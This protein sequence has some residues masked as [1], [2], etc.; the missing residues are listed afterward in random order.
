[1]DIK[2]LKECGIEAIKDS[3]L[4]VLDR[5]CLLLFAFAMGMLAYTLMY[6]TGAFYIMVLCAMVCVGI[7]LAR[8]FLHSAMV[9]VRYPLV[10]YLKKEKGYAETYSIH[11]LDTIA[12]LCETVV[13]VLFILALSLW[14]GLLMAVLV[15]LAM[16][17]V[18]LS[19]E[20]CKDETMRHALQDGITTAFYFL[21]FTI[22]VLLI[23]NQDVSADSALSILLALLFSMPQVSIKE[24][25][26]SLFYSLSFPLMAYTTAIV[27]LQLFQLLEIPVLYLDALLC[28]L[29]IGPACFVAAMHLW[30]PKKE[31]KLFLSAL[32]LAIPVI[33]I[34]S[35]NLFSLL[36]GVF[37]IVARLFLLP[38]MS[39]TFSKGLEEKE[40]D[41]D[42]EIYALL[43]QQSDAPG[44]FASMFTSVLFVAGMT[45]LYLRGMV[46]YVAMLM[47]MMAVIGY[48]HSPSVSL[49]A[50]Q[51]KEMVQH[52]L[53]Q[54]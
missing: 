2:L 5:A 35:D 22:M 36:M 38:A 18:H 24:N 53:H 33:F 26:F 3:L 27:V 19:C 6:G 4:H 1:M 16:V 49:C 15:V 44:V 30:K 51:M 17:V 28:F 43:Q 8:T 32:V 37:V 20:K 46:T 13:S 31:R 47:G 9:H 12:N 52:H 45:L 25:I 54:S 48:M 41:D 23:R 34:V 7:I 50:L 29:C 39:A 11:Q 42:E 21:T 10:L 40:E 14:C